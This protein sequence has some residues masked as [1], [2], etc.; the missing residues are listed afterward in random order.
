MVE[1]PFETERLADVESELATIFE[2]VRRMLRFWMEHPKNKWLD[3]SSLPADVLDLAMILNVQVYRHGRSTLELCQ[4]GEGGDAMISCRALFETVLAML[5]ILKPRVGLVAVPEL[6]KATGKPKTTA[7][8]TAKFRAVLHKRK[9]GGIVGKL[10]RSDRANLYLAHAAFQDKVFAKKCMTIPGCK[11]TGRLVDRSIT[12]SVVTHFEG[13][14]GPEWAYILTHHP[15][16]YSGLSVSDLAKELHPRMFQWYST[17]YSYQSRV[18]HAADA[19]RCATRVGGIIRPVYFSPD[20]ELMGTLEALSMLLLTCMA[21]M[22]RYIGFG[23]SI[24]M[25]IPSFNKDRA[26]IFEDYVKSKGR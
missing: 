10:S 16:T 23:P 19:L 3:K 24:D 21:T 18:V 20:H 6:D 2:F 11:R 13:R 4:R 9:A 5:F 26:T 7:A 14:V 8:G 1:F 17:I 22:Q 25:V 12:P 15:H